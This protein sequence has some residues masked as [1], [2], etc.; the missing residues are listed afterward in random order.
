MKKQDIS[1]Q[2][3][4]INKGTPSLSLLDEQENIPQFEERTILF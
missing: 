4:K 2:D 1:H 3:Q